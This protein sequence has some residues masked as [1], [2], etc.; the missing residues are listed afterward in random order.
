[1]KYFQ[2]KD[3]QKVVGLPKHRYEYI[4][5]KIGIKPDVE[6]VEGT[7]KHHL[8]SFKN[9]LEFAFV[10]RANKMSITPKTIKLMLDFLS[11]DELKDAGFFD[12][13]K[14]I[15]ASL[16]FVIFDD[17]LYYKL[18]GESLQKQVTKILFPVKG[19]DK[20]FEMMGKFKS[21]NK[22]ESITIPG[23][24]DEIKKL[25]HLTSMDLEDS[26]GYV[27]INLGNI[28]DRILKKLTE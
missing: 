19:F 1:M 10:H 15:K 17:K 27:T 16:H 7:G 26:D 11:N 5:S 24:T 18:S 28:K 4:A 8:Y 20:I 23:F 22:D 12:P 21:R 9:L 6:E 14:S 2:A 25:M 3:I 13:K